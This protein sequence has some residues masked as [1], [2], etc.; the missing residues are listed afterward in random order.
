MCK[1]KLLFNGIAHHCT[2]KGARRSLSRALLFTGL[3]L[4]AAPVSCTPLRSVVIH[5]TSL[6]YIRSPTALARYVWVMR[7]V[8]FQFKRASRITTNFTRCQRKAHSTPFR[9]IHFLFHSAGRSPPAALVVLAC[10]CRPGCHDFC[11]PTCWP[12]LD[13]SLSTTNRT[14]QKITPALVWCSRSARYNTHSP[15][16]SSWLAP[17]L[18]RS[19]VRAPC[20]HPTSCSRTH[21]D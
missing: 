5:C 4:T 15:R 17:A 12:L 9:S 19:S 2:A 16:L 8:Y 11:I 1:V 6:R 10:A 13:Q 7:S 18:P 21:P 20:S 3:P 14:K